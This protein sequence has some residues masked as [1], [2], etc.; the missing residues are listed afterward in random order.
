MKANT[1]KYEG[2]TLE[3]Y[4]SGKGRKVLLVFHGIGQ[5]HTFF[6]GFAEALGKEYTLFVFNLFFHGESYWHKKENPL[7]KTYWKKIMDQFFQKEKIGRFSM[8]GFSMGGKF[9]WAT[10][11][12]FPTRVAK[13]MMMAP[14]GIDT[15]I[16][17]DM[18]T[19]PGLLR[20]YFRSMVVRPKRFMK[21]V[22][23]MRTLGIVDKSVEK[24]TV[25]Q[26]DSRRKRRQVY[27]SWIVFRALKFDVEALAEIIRKHNIQLVLYI[28]KYDRI[29]TKKSVSKLLKYLPDY[30]LH[31]MESGH[32]DLVPTIV[33]ELQK[34]QQAP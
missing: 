21:L 16:W 26:M 14:D 32:H 9:V 22:K 18:A 29:I 6:K 17:Y 34:N 5:D 33:R 7:A 1:I 19:Y 27:F 28:G 10:M 4:Q 12:C 2:A 30:E 23:S 24:F 11:E 8:A 13:L 31:M 25:R 20:K 3:Y 15:Q